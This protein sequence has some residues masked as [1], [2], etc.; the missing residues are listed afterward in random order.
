[1]EEV[2]ESFKSKLYHKSLSSR[3]SKYK[4]IQGKITE[5]YHKRYN[6]LIPGSIKE[7]EFK[8]KYQPRISSF[9]RRFKP[10]DSQLNILGHDHLPT[11]DGFK[12]IDLPKS[13]FGRHK[14]YNE[15]NIVI[16]HH[17]LSNDSPNNSSLIA[18]RKKLA[19]MNKKC[20]KSKQIKNIVSKRINPDYQTFST[21]SGFLYCKKN[22]SVLKIYELENEKFKN[23][24][25]LRHKD[26]SD[27]NSKMIEINIKDKSKRKISE[28]VSRLYT[29]SP[30]HNLTYLE[31]NKKYSKL[32]EFDN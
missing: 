16:D 5:L 11:E 28:I 6:K 20:N 13:P 18:F 30:T 9:S 23:L 17:F 3:F 29:P 27:L 22:K 4:E 24:N 8:H 21:N 1:M 25:Q 14:T 7:I 31:T 10:K 12:I 15:N 2:F 32:F 19:L 26:S